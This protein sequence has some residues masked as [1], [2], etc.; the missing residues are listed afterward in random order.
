MRDITVEYN[1]QPMR[2]LRVLT[3]QQ[4]MRG[5]RKFSAAND[6]KSKIYS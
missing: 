4:P 2:G 3:L 5:I 1:Q 6:E